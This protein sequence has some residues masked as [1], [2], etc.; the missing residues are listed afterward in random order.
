KLEEID[1][2]SSS[3]SCVVIS[4]VAEHACLV[5]FSEEDSP[6]AAV[7]SAAA[8]RT[9]IPASFPN[10]PSIT[11]WPCDGAPLRVSGQPVDDQDLDLKQCRHPERIDG[12][13]QQRGD[14]KERG[15]MPEEG[16]RR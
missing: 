14:R 8:S 15:E 7:P 2:V 1:S 3:L 12:D 9:A 13:R 16:Q 11:V 5:A 10:I 4:L 6:R